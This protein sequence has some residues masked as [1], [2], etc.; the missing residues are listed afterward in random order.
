MMA[1]ISCSCTP[2]VTA[3]VCVVTVQLTRPRGGGLSR[4]VP[5]T[6]A[7]PASSSTSKDRNEVPRR[8]LEVAV[9]VGPLVL[10]EHVR[11]RYAL[12][13]V[14]VGDEVRPCLVDV[15]LHGAHRSRV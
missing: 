5:S 7:D 8:R 15:E 2:Q 9:G 1:A 6:H 13:W 11:H 14:G 12:A 3:D 4:S 10:G